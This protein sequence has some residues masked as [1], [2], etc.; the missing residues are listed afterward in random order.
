M[1]L[2]FTVTGMACGHCSGRVKAALEAA[3]GVNFALVSHED[4]TAEVDF[5]ENVITAYELMELIGEQG[6]DASLPRG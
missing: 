3:Q 6:F 5:D 1:N 4:G 2:V